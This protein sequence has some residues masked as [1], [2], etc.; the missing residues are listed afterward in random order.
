MERQPQ[1]Q[2]I[3]APIRTHRRLQG[4]A[5]CR[6]ERSA[7]DPLSPR[8]TRPF[9]LSR[10]GKAVPTSEEMPWSCQFRVVEQRSAIAPPHAFAEIRTLRLVFDSEPCAVDQREG[11]QP[12][13]TVAVAPEWVDAGQHLVYGVA[14]RESVDTDDRRAIHIDALDV[15]FLAQRS[16]LL[17]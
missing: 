3:A 11:L 17:W 4:R 7:S 5:S 10:C 6:Q 1:G 12:E 14:R 2:F 16:V 9:D 13:L 15:A 8:R